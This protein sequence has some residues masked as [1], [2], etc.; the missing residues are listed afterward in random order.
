MALDERLKVGDLLG[1]L[2]PHGSWVRSDCH[3]SDNP[4]RIVDRSFGARSVGSHGLCEF[5][6]R[7]SDG[8]A[9]E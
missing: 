8:R 4:S 1:Q 6:R 5:V 7:I 3:L 9:T 2:A